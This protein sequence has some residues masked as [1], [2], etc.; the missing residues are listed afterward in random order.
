MAAM[1]I[2]SLMFIAGCSSDDDDTNGVRIGSLQDEEFQFMNTIMRS[3]I[4]EMDGYTIDMNFALIDELMQP[5]PPGKLVPGKY[6]EDIIYF[7]YGYDTSNYWHIFACTAAIGNDLDSWNLVGVDSIR[8]YTDDYVYFP[9]SLPTEVNLRAHFAIELESGPDAQGDLGHHALMDLTGI[10]DLD[11][12]EEPEELVI[13]G[14]SSDTLEIYVS[15]GDTMSCDFHMTNSQTI[16][17]IVLDTL[18]M[19]YDACPASGAINMAATVAMSCTGT[20]ELDVNGR[21]SVNFVFGEGGM[22]AIYESGNT[23]WTYTEDCREPSPKY[24]K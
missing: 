20:E 2:I 19:D 10:V 18:A 4:M 12:D 17:N 8:F 5:Y 22:T 15:E 16:S 23:R 6:L 9:E 1:I 14:S 24:K 3:A 21:W 13:S 11:G 7:S